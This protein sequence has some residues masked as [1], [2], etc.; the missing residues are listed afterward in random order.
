MQEKDQIFFQ[1]FG[2]GSM[3]IRIETAPLDPD[4]YWEH[5]SASRTVKML[6][7]KGEKFVILS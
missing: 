6:S 2:S 5:G 4:P 7:K 3:W 1:C